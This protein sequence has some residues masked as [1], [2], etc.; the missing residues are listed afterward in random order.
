[1][2]GAWWHNLSHLYASALALLAARAVQK[3]HPAFDGDHLICPA[4]APASLARVVHIF[5]SLATRPGPST[6]AQRTAEA[7]RQRLNRLLG[8]LDLPTRPPSPRPEPSSS[9][10]AVVAPPVT[11]M[12]NAALSMTSAYGAIDAS[13]ANDPF[14]DSLLGLDGAGANAAADGHGLVAVGGG[15]G[16]GMDDFMGGGYAFPIDGGAGGALMADWGSMD[17]TLLGD[18]EQLSWTW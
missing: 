12:S 7:C 9:A 13:T 10:A 8:A 18:G 16:G 15:A 1:M 5:D 14:F 6:P 3:R 17:L 11:T 4:D 2:V